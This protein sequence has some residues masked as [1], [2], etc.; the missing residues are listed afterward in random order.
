MKTCHR[1]QLPKDN[2]HK[3]SVASDGLDH[4]CK[5]CR[6]IINASQSDYKR[7][8]ELAKK[9]NLTHDGYLAIMHEQDWLCAICGK[10]AKLHI[11][12]DHQTGKVR[13]ACCGDCNRGLGMF[14]DSASLLLRAAS[15]LRDQ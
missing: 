2:Y 13:G 15:Y 6:R 3:R 12:H 7:E 9:Y 14:R 11:D 8:W 10:L 1:C 4:T 5:D